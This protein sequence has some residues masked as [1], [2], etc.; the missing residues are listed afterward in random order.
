MIASYFRKKP[1]SNRL[2][3]KHTLSTEPQ[4]TKKLLNSYLLISEQE[5]PSFLAFSRERDHIGRLL[6]VSNSFFH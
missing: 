1:Y 3:K 4:N 6:S 5:A 2:R